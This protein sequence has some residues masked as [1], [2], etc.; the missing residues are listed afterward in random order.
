MHYRV[1][2]GIGCANIHVFIQCNVVHFTLNLC[3]VLVKYVNS[4]NKPGR[5]NCICMI[6]NNVKEIQYQ[7][8]MFMS[9]L[10]LLLFPGVKNNPT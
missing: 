9:R 2:R 6:C 1:M 8:L 4:I 7:D 10:N 5:T 3:T